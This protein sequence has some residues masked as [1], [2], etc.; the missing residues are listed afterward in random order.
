MS[1]FANCQLPADLHPVCLNPEHSGT[2]SFPGD[3]A[4]AHRADAL[5]R[6]QLLAGIRSYDRCVRNHSKKIDLQLQFM[7]PF[8][9]MYFAFRS[10]SCVGA[11]PIEIYTYTQLLLRWASIRPTDTDWGRAIRLNG[12]PDCLYYFMLLSSLCPNYHCKAKNTSS[13]INFSKSI[14]HPIEK[15][16]IIRVGHKSHPRHAKIIVA[17]ILHAFGQQWPAGAE[18]YSKH[19]RFYTMAQFP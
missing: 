3:N 17:Q 6:E 16:A 11:G 15:C 12:S 14:G 1:Q 7:T 19:I 13:I 4:S 9:S 2:T 8:K 10:A 18:Y 5:K